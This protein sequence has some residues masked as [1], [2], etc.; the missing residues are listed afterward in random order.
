MSIL[1][2]ISKLN[3]HNYRKWAIE[4]KHLL[5]HF[6][7]WQ[8]VDGSEIIPCPPAAPAAS[9]SSKLLPLQILSILRMTFN[10]NEMILRI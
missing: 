1:T 5:K 6:N 8:V 9:G 3:E 4:D 10:L 7:V 2:A